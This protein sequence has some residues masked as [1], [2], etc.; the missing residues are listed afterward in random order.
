MGAKGQRKVSVQAVA[1]ALLAHRGIIL[2]AAR[3][4][5]VAR[6]TVGEY[7]KESEYL[8]AIQEEAN[9]ELI[10]VAE[11]E[12]YKHIKAGNLTALIY[13]LRTKGRKRGW[14]QYEG[15]I[16]ETGD[17]GVA[18]QDVKSS[19]SKFRSGVISFADKWEEAQKRSKES[20]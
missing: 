11:G 16:P 3:A 20:V 10:D 13:F 15:T 14:G 18:A 4:L 19:A 7:L 2:D 5:G 8:R 1:K 12:L 6:K 17:N 9:N